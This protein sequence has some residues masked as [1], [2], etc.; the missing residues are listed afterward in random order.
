MC[1][2]LHR[3]A[4]RAS[5]SVR[6]SRRVLGRAL[7]RLA[8]AVPCQTNQLEPVAR[9]RGFQAVW[10]LSWRARSAVLVLG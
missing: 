5:R 4:E 8:E 9:V 6:R 3:A 1:G 10:Q 7:A 2:A